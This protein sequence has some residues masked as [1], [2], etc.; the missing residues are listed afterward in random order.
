MDTTDVKEEYPVGYKFLELFAGYGGFTGAV[1]E[2]CGLSVEVMDEQD[3]WTTE[4][5]I[6]NDEHFEKAKV[7][8]R[9]ADHTH[10]APPCKSMTRAR[11][12]DEH[13]S[14]PVIRS[15]ANPMGWG[16]PLAEEGN[17]IAERTSILVDCALE[18][19]GGYSV[20]NPW[21][22]FLWELPVMKR[23]MK[24]HMKVKLDQCAYGAE[25][26]KPTGILTSV[27]WMQKVAKVC[28]DVISHEHVVLVGKTYNYFYDPPRL[29]WKT[30]LAAEY[31]AGLCWAWAKELKGF[32]EAEE[33]K[34]ELWE[35]KMSKVGQ[36]KL[37]KKVKEDSSGSLREQREWENQQAV[38]G[39][40]NPYQA[41][42]RTPAMWKVG[43]LMRAAVLKA[44]KR[45]VNRLP[46][47]R[48]EDLYGLTQGLDPVLVEAAIKELA[49][50]TGTS[51]EEEPKP[52]RSGMIK[53]LLE[54]GGGPEKH[55]PVWME[56]GFPLGIEAPLE[57]NN[58]FPT[59]AEGTKAVEA[60]RNFQTL[61]AMADVLQAENYKSFQEAG[62]PAEAELERIAQLGYATWAADW[63]TVTASVGAGAALT[64][65]GCVQKEKP[66]GTLKTRLIVD[67]RRSG[68][69]GKMTI[70]QRVVLPRVTE[71][72]TSWQQLRAMY[73]G[74]PLTL[75]RID[76]KD[77]FYTCRLNPQ[78][79][80]FAVVRGRKGY[81]ILNVVAFGLAC[82]PLLWGR[83]AA[84][85]MR[86]ASSMLP[87]LRLQC[88]VDDPILVL[89]G[90]DELQHRMGLIM[91]CLLWQALGS[92][93]AWNKLQFGTSVS[94]IGFQL[95]LEGDTF[96]AT[97]AT[98]KLQK[99]QRLLQELLQL[100]GMLPLAKLRTLAGVLGW[101]TSII[102]FARPWVSMI[103]GAITEA[104]SR[105]PVKARQRKNLVFKKQVQLALQ[106][107]FRLSQ[108]PELRATFHPQQRGPSFTIQTDASPWGMGGILWGPQGAVAWWAQDL[109]EEDFNFLGA[110][111]GDP[112][113][114]TE[115]ELVAIILS[116]TAFMEHVQC[117]AVSLLSDNTGALETTLQLRSSKPGMA[118]LAAE[119]VLTLRDI[120]SQVAFGRHLRS[121]ANYLADALSRLSVG[122]S[123][124]SQLKE[125][126]RVA[127]PVRRWGQ[128]AAAGYGSLEVGEADSGIDKAF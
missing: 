59:T 41:V 127:P 17:L 11:R 63:E 90:Q 124:P 21:D 122:K 128:W 94:W 70:R 5:D 34:Q 33:I 99:L 37:D 12:E 80:K 85:M 51:P 113:W 73:Q 14:V 46:T 9:E 98:D 60:S 1:R 79:K 117:K 82:G 97:L 72:A 36:N 47:G 29:V 40:R 103:W 123:I 115:W 61:T 32:L 110:T 44:M 95:H 35:R 126:P 64:K 119:L 6:T 57:T 39:L 83:T 20:E 91:A 65:F 76:F 50:V 74:Q 71:V 67:M 104:E 19:N 68:I 109:Q 55:V 43:G 10:L 27:R 18:N 69:N 111:P 81:Y 24:K 62:E 54:I 25:S 38:G 22:S 52:Y 112:A 78:E 30:S 45:A 28:G 13:G 77:A 120:D 105:Q 7:W 4:W 118:V 101:L 87:E 75:A 102:V 106:V 100:K 107:V 48:A 26:K 3:Q 108:G 42:A 96:V 116:L 125:A 86:L 114:Q 84:V 23:H 92:G 2:A 66:D 121:A 58:V 16:H 15:D 8:A 88:F 53:R 49:M 93:L 89:S 31:P 56:E